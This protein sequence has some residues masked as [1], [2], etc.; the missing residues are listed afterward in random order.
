MPFSFAR[1]RFSSGFA[2]A[3][4]GKP[5][6]LTSFNGEKVVPPPSEAELQKIENQFSR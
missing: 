5:Y 2:T 4:S 6:R 3:H 1:D